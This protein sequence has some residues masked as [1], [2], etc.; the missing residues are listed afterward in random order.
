MPYT[1][2][3]NIKD[4]RTALMLSPE[5]VK[6]YHLRVSQSGSNDECRRVNAWKIAKMAAKILHGNFGA[7]RVAV[8][9][10]LAEGVGFSSNSDIDIAA[11]DIPSSEYYNALININEISSDF[12]IDLVDPRDC[13]DA[14][15]KAVEETGVD[16]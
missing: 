12:M 3:L 15:R 16:L 7:Q 14:I 6:Q 13:R 9:G 10:S 1:K 8:F 2:R 11:W 4:S 5:E